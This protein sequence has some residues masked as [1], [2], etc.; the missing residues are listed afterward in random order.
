MYNST[1][2]DS[3]LKSICSDPKSFEKLYMLLRKDVFACAYSILTNI[4]LSEDAV[5]ETFIRLYSL[6]K[7][8]TPQGYAKA[9]ILKVC[10]NVSMEIKRQHSN[11]IVTDQPPEQVFYSDNDDS[12]FVEELLSKLSE[13]E[14][15][16]I[17]LHCYSDLTFKE[18]SKILSIP[19]STVKYHHRKALSKC[20][21][22]ALCA[23]SINLWAKTE[24][25]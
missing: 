10:K 8:Y 22:R 23:Y 25:A 7:K 9:Y 1:Y 15:Q 20:R 6:S 12:I 13:K 21:K 24:E 19:E 18:I 16:V 4:E 2:V 11:H 17:I 14:R 3:L 5:N